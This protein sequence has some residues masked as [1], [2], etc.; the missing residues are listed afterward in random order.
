MGRLSSWRCY[1]ARK[2]MGRL[3][4]NWKL[5]TKG[6]TDEAISRNWIHVEEWITLNDNDARWRSSY[7]ARRVEAINS[8]SSADS[9][10]IKWKHEGPQWQQRLCIWDILGRCIHAYIT[11]WNQIKEL[12][13]PYG[14]VITTFHEYNPH[15]VPQQF[16]IKPFNFFPS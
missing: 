10:L 9:F 15:F 1:E 4:W 2:C 3:H 12:I 7:N 14:I 5:Q 8:E 11:T 13:K 6:G 16:I